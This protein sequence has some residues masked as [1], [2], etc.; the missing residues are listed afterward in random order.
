VLRP[1]ANIVLNG[2]APLGVKGRPDAYGMPQFREQLNNQ[3]VANIVAFM[4]NGLGNHAAAVSANEVSELRKRSD[5][6][7]DRV[8]ILKMR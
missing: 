8:V 6:A 7:S 3:Q 1:Q 5:P 2:S 4:R